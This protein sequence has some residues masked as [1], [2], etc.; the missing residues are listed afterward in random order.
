MIPAKLAAV[1]AEIQAWSPPVGCEP[2]GVFIAYDLTGNSERLTVV[3]AKCCVK[4]DTKI[5]WTK[6]NPASIHEAL[7]GQAQWVA[8]N[9]R[10]SHKERGLLPEAEPEALKAAGDDFV[11]RIAKHAKRDQ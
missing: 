7:D 11:A 1:V 9:Y 10:R 8:E 5:T 6:A 2:D 3:L 4:G